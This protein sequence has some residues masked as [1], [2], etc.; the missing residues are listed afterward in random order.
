MVGPRP[1]PIPA[2]LEV[3]AQKLDWRGAEVP[4][5]QLPSFELTHF[6]GGASEITSY[7]WRAEGELHPHTLAP[8][9]PSGL[10]YCC[11]LCDPTLQRDFIRHFHDLG[12]PTACG[13]FKE[14]TL[15]NPEVVKETIE[16]ADIFFCNRSEA[17]ELFGSLGQARTEPGKLLFITLSSDGAIVVQGAHATHV[18]GAPVKELDPTGA[19]DTFCGTVL[20]HL[21]QGDHPVRAGT[22][23]AVAAA[24]MI[25]GIGPERLLET[26]KPS[27]S[28]QPAAVEISTSRIE[29]VGRVL[30]SLPEAS[31][32]DF[33]GDDYPPVDHPAALDFF[34]AATLQQFGFWSTKDGTYDQPMVADLDGRRLKG[35]DFL[36]AA[37]RRWLDEDPEGLAPRSQAQ[38][39]P[40]V[41]DHRLRDDRG[42]NPLPAA[43]LHC[44]QA[45]AYGSDL[46]ALGSTPSKIVQN[47]MRSDRPLRTFLTSLDHVS[48]YKE[49][50]LRKKAAL[51]AAILYARPERYLVWDSNEEIPPIIDYHLQRSCLRIGL[52]EVSDT[53][54]M[55][56]LEN[57]QT[58]SPIEES[59]V[60]EAAFRALVRMRAQTAKSM[61]ALDWFFFQNRQ[62]CPEM[63]EPDCS[64]CPIDPVCSRRKE[65]F[66]PVIRTTFY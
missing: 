18:P 54:L 38:L 3:A 6:G 64:Q 40:E 30:D 53:D 28:R 31:A 9:L 16:L 45:I 50:P 39:T 26:G 36:W 35:S 33:T 34:F 41:F 58:V 63:T 52:I 17:I 29:Q 49:D 47:A 37:Y 10:V 65:L 42:T 12:Q 2:E 25:Q 13:T 27:P 15:R 7:E 51:L 4:P 22:S 48:G 60:R 55:S 5:E 66:Q 61:A 11:P 57:R 19:G 56:K 14:A 59:Q 20:A 44:E 21:L 1:Y 23:G 24:E 32:F 62:R 46:T 43:S 8:D